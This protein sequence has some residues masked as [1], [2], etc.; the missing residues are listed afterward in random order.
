MDVWWD[1]RTHSVRWRCAIVIAKFSPRRFAEAFNGT[2]EVHTSIPEMHLGQANDWQHLRNWNDCPGQRCVLYT[3]IRFVVD[4]FCRRI[5][6]RQSFLDFSCATLKCLRSCV[7]SCGWFTPIV[8]LTW[9]L[10]E[11]LED[12]SSWPEAWGRA[13]LQLVPFLPRLSIP[14]FVGSWRRSSH[15]IRARL[16]SYSLL[17]AIMPMTLQWLLRP[18]DDWWMLSPAFKVVDQIAGL[19]LNHRKCF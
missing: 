14:F 10:Q 6:H 3:R 15:R 11:R 8:L 5:S 16:T 7:V 2:H 13:A 1:Y 9:N 17:R 19:N 12:N 4:G 18:F